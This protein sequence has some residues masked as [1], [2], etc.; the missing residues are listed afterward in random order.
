MFAWERFQI[1]PWERFQRFAWQNGRGMTG[2][3]IDS[4]VYFYFDDVRVG[5]PA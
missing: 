4:P 3:L 2:V 1:F 5:I